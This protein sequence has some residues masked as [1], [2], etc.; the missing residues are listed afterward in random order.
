MEH[1]RAPRHD[2]Q[3]GVEY[4][5]KGTDTAEVG[6]ARNISIGGMLIEAETLPAFGDEITV[7][8]QIT[9]GGPIFELPAIVRW[10]TAAAMGIQFQ[11]IGVREANAITELRTYLESRQ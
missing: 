7:R 5:K 10:T 4:R 9:A 11:S 3:M 1:R 2:I 6:T 8:F